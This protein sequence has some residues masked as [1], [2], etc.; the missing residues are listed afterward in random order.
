MI[1]SEEKRKRIKEDITRWCKHT[2]TLPLLREGDIESLTSQIIDEFYHIT[3]CCGHSVR[4]FSDGLLI[5][6]YTYPDESQGTTQGIYCKDCA[7]SYIKDKNIK[8]WIVKPNKG[9]K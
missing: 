9:S 6:F 4:D 1:E 5:E 7:D 2:K 3:L 8:A